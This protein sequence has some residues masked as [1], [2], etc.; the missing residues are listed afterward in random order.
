MIPRCFGMFYKSWKIKACIRTLG[1]LFALFLSVHSTALAA[2]E[3]VSAGDACQTDDDCSGLYP[4]TGSVCKS[5]ELYRGDYHYT[6]KRCARKCSEVVARERT[7][8]DPSYIS[9]SEL[10]MLFNQAKFFIYDPA[11]GVADDAYAYYT[12]VRSGSFVEALNAGDNF[13]ESGILSTDFCYKELYNVYIPSKKC[14]G[15]VHFRPGIDSGQGGENMTR[16]YGVIY[17]CISCPAG[18][19]P[20]IRSVIYSFDKVDSKLADHQDMNQYDYCDK[21]AHQFTY[22]ND[23]AYVSRGFG[24]DD[25][26][27][28]SCDRQSDTS[29]CSFGC[30]IP[31]ELGC[32]KSYARLPNNQWYNNEPWDADVTV[33]AN[34]MD[35]CSEASLNDPIGALGN[36]FWATVSSVHDTVAYQRFIH[37]FAN[38][39]VHVGNGLQSAS[40]FCRPTEVSNYCDATGC[41]ELAA[42]PTS[43]SANWWSPPTE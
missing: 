31:I 38:C 30:N 23:D 2:V 20:K 39:W 42:S 7:A 19:K 1:V 35:E 37:G 36:G 8:L 17:H 33:S 10:Q 13:Q 6:G 22:P 26:V 3:E 5:F 21:R 32:F 28:C 15:W 43:C 12:Y 34:Y 14:Y 25:F 4:N 16:F 24:R 18:Y 29:Y 27:A 41:F 11:T 40:G 9:G